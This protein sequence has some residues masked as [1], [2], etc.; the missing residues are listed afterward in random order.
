MHVKMT[1]YWPTIGQL[2]RILS[3]HW[4]FNLSI[5]LCW[6]FVL[7]VIIF[8]DTTYKALLIFISNFDIENLSFF[9]IFV[10][11]TFGVRKSLKS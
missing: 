2:K 9:G 11:P 3:C 5:G 1:S 4:Y 10:D 8:I 7:Y 6:S